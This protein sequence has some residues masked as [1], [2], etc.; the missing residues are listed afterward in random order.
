MN[1]YLRLGRR[2]VVARRFSRIPA[3]AAARG[4]AFARFS[5]AYACGRG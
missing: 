5:I 1:I 4:R 3:A 2:V